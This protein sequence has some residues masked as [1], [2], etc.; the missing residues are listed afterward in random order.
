M[1]TN[2]AMCGFVYCRVSTREQGTDDHYSLG[3]QE[4]RCRD[5]AKMKSWPVSVLA[6][7][8][9]L[10]TASSNEQ[11]ITGGIRHLMCQVEIGLRLLGVF[12]FEPYLAD[13]PAAQILRPHSAYGQMDHEL[14]VPT[15][16]GRPHTR[17]KDPV[18]I[19]SI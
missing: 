17:L 14:S 10:L 19:W 16:L 1:T 18:L 8:G 4:Q 15:N 12:S 5:Y 7:R 9:K 11:A 13:G 2:Q 6:G 3:N